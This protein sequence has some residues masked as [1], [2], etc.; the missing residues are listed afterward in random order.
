VYELFCLCLFFCVLWFLFF[1]LSQFLVMNCFVCV[2][3]GGSCFVCFFL[4][5]KMLVESEQFFFLYVCL[6][7]GHSGYVCV[8]WVVALWNELRNNVNLVFNLEFDKKFWGWV[9]IWMFCDNLFQIFLCVVT[10]VPF[11]S[12]QKMLIKSE[13]SW[14]FV[15]K[16]LA[17][18][19]MCMFHK[20]FYK[21]N[22]RAT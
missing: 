10:I 1:S 17:T 21:V 22:K 15:C 13:R 11:F 19:T 8:L 16:K 18:M 14:F 4:C 20:L 9:F 6:M 3:Q 12:P 5:E 2:V 7:Q